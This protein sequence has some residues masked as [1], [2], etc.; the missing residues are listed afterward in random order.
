MANV[1]NPFAP[2][3]DNPF[4]KADA[5]ADPNDLELLKADRFQRW[6][7]AFIDGMIPVIVMVPLGL[8]ALAIDG[9]SLFDD[10]DAIEGLIYLGYFMAMMPFTLLNWYLIVT[11]GQTLGKMAVGTRIVSEEG[12]PVDFVK[13][14]SSETGSSR[15][16]TASAASPA[17]STW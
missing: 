2:G 1:D 15:S 14:S 10:P 7:G 16:S 11:R 4:A 6:L 12:A 9:G 3:G 13:G 5:W 17:S 8:G